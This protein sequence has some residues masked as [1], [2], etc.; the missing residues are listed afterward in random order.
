M[1]TIASVAILAVSTAA[2]A[3]VGTPEQQKPPRSANSMA[4]ESMSIEALANRAAPSN[5]M[6][7]DP[8]MN[9]IPPR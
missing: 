7:P 5:T 8:T 1:S 4:N 9:S 6:S 3:Q 2:L